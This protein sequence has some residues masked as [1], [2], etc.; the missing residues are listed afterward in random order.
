[1]PFSHFTN[2]IFKPQI[3][4]LWAALSAAFPNL[5]K[6]GSCLSARLGAE[7]CETAAGSAAVSGTRFMGVP[8]IP[9]DIPDISVGVL[10]Y[11]RYLWVSWFFAY[12][13]SMG[14]L[15]FL[16]FAWLLLGAT[17]VW[18]ADP[19]PGEDFCQGPIHSIEFAGNK[20]TKSYVMLG[21]L[22]FKAGS[23]CSLDH[24][25]DG[26]QSIMDLGLFRSVSAEFSRP[27]DRL[28]VTYT[29]RE[30]IY[31][32]P[33]PRFSRSSD[34]ELRLGAQ[35][36]WDNFLGRNH[37]VKLTAERREE[38]DGN[39]PAG[40]H[41]ELEYEIPR[42]FMSAT[43][44]AT[45]FKFQTKQ[46]DL[47]QDGIEFGVANNNDSQFAL[48]L[49]RWANSGGVTKGLRYR[50][51]LRIFNREQ[52][53]LEGE[54]GPFTE[55]TDVA[56]SVGFE[57]IDVRD[58]LF[59]LNGMSFGANLQLSSSLFGSDFSYNRLD[60]FFRRYMPLRGLKLRNLNYQLRLGISDNGPFGLRHFSIGGGELFR[61]RQK[62]SK[63]GDILLLANIE[64]LVSLFG[65]QA[66][67]GVLF[68][69]IGNVYRHNEF[70]PTDLKFGFGAG[71]RYK[72]LS[73]SKTDLRF[74]AAWDTD[75]ESLRYYIST[76]LT[77]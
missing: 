49:S 66:L 62:Q 68:T 45:A 39:G 48:E 16:V 36:R 47:E 32:L 65:K 1:M 20:A 12:S 75:R 60:L 33:L 19:V 53:L 6:P 13:K 23:V 25:V 30:K 55:G 77:F 15:V 52:E 54:A 14:V 8:D 28:T 37:H 70:D 44:L 18:A 76:D 69:D 17:K 43:G 74:D 56:L 61:G 26:L 4:E 40:K 3:K 2:R 10:V 59:R 72:L 34:G 71:I 35:L 46:V 67:R 9:P 41:Y 31:F 50:G 22:A 7:G 38:D 42:F 5:S 21:Q 27:D 51:G 29:V 64:Y 58:E 57:K 73:F 11:C 63:T 24:V